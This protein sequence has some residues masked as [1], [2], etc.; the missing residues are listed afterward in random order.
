MDIKNY[1][2]GE[3]ELPLDKIP[4]DGGFTG[5]L[6]SI[7][8]IGDSLS[9]GEF[10]S[11]DESGTQKGYHDMFSF[12]WGQHIA[13][14]TGCRVYNFS[15]GGMTA[16]RYMES[17]AEQ[18]GFWNEDKLCRAYILALGVNDLVNFKQEIGDIAD[19]NADDCTKNADTFCGYFAA[20][21]QRLKLMQPKAKFFLMTMPRYSEEYA[22]RNKIATEH[23]ILMHKLAKYFDNTYVIDFNR[24]APVYDEQFKKAFFL[25]GHMNAAGYKLTGDMV[26]SYIDY[27]IR[28]DFESFAQVGFIGTDVHNYT[29]KW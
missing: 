18:N 9:S 8:C 10:E 1:Y 27:I 2:L 11:T 12:S 29:A 28:S 14:R 3:N 26:M 7:A 21:I 17:F 22:E 13:R 15:A 24:Y 5:I 25:G 20:I 6:E 19:I 23:A 16:K 4:T